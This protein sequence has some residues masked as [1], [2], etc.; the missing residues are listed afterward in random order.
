MASPRS[1]S[2]DEE[3]QRGSVD[4]LS[5]YARLAAAM[6]AQSWG[7]LSF[8]FRDESSGRAS[9]VAVKM[10]HLASPMQSPA[11]VNRQ[12]AEELEQEDVLKGYFEEVTDEL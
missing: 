5:E 7:D 12:T 10:A 8:A 1:P 2:F 9:E 4:S 11:P 3:E 6:N